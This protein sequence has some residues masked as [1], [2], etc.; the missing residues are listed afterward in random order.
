MAVLH[1][2]RQSAKTNEHRAGANVRRK[3][4]RLVP[5]EA[6]VNS[7]TVPGVDGDV[8]E[9]TTTVGVVDQ[10]TRR[11]FLRTYL[12]PKTEVTD[13]PVVE[14]DA[15]R[16]EGARHKHGAVLILSEL[17]DRSAEDALVPA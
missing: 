3:L 6:A 9:S 4:H 16:S 14:V 12:T 1:F 15:D 11:S 7:A 8:S 5:V 2:L 13:G 17:P 10:I